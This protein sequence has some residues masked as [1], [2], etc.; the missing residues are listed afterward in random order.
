[1]QALTGTQTGGR[2]PAGDKPGTAALTDEE[3][4]VCNQ[5]GMTAEEYRKA[6]GA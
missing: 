3:Q 5:L 4:Y 1:M 2:T 6:K